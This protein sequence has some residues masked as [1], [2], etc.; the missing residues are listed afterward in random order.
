MRH[1]I[2]IVMIVG[3]GAPVAR[4]VPQPNKAAAAGIV[5][6]AAAALTL[7]D[8]KAAAQTAE[9][10]KTADEKKPQQSGGTVPPDVFDRLDQQQT[11]KQPQLQQPLPPSGEP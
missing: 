1:L 3:C 2:I 8:P 11:T 6:G 7:A 5:A 9:S 10:A 4:N